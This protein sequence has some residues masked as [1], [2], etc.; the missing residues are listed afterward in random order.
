MSESPGFTF[1]APIGGVP[2]DIDFAPSIL[3]AV[4]YGLLAVL[5]VHRMLHPATRTLCILGVLSFVGE[6]CAYP[7]CPLHWMPI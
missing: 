1:P 2:F 6:R 5:A 3:F 7:S 4:L